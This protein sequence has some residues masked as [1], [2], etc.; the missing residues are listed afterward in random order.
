MATVLIPD[1]SPLC[2]SFRDAGDMRD[3][4]RVW[5]DG[6]VLRIDARGRWPLQV[7]KAYDR[8]IRRIIAACR[9]ISPHLRVI[10]DRS[11][12]P[13]FDPGGHELLLATYSEVLREGDRVALV[14]D[15]SVT[16]GHIRRIAGREE[17]QAFLSL[18]AA[19]T[20]VLAYG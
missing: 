2:A 15:S 12:I 10:A 13:S 19:R 17:T 7:A 18:S 1:E 6:P 4:Y 11:E 20:W 16:K 8:D 9:L 5:A 3:L 14:V